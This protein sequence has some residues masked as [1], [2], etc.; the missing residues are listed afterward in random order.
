MSWLVGWLADGVEAE[1]VVVGD[2]LLHHDERL[3]SLHLSI[4]YAL[5]F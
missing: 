4:G 5:Q 1:V 3:Q 2:D